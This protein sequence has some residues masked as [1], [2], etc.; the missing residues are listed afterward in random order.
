MKATVFAVL[1]S[2]FLPAWTYYDNPDSQNRFVDEW[3][4]NMDRRFAGSYQPP[5]EEPDED[6]AWADEADWY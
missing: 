6:D 2:L 4:E 3:G 5:V 1:S